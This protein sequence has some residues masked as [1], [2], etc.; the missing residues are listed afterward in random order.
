MDL[1]RA[2][3]AHAPDGPAWNLSLGLSR[4][5]PAGVVHAG[6]WASRPTGMLSV[7]SHHVACERVKV[8]MFAGLPSSGLRTVRGDG[9]HAKAR[10]LILK[11]QGSSS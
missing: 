1:R 10:F 2:R 9:Q 3:R 5:P 11:N 4:W 7:K 8:P 6:D